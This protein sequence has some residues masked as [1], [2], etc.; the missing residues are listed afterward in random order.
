MHGPG[1]LAT[2]GMERMQRGRRKRMCW[3]TVGICWYS[4]GVCALCVLGVHLGTDLIFPQPSRTV[5]SSGSMRATT[6]RT[7]WIL[8]LCV[9][10]C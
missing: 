6:G 9:L 4:T 8:C 10:C 5:V 3:H 1:N 2:G 7:L